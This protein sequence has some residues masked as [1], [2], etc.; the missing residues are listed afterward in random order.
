MKK[1]G[2]LLAALAIAAAILLGVW[3]YFRPA[4]TEGRDRKS[5]G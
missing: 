4:T 1:N 3:M 2:M 5:V